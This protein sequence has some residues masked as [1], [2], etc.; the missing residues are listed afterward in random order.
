MEVK[1][2]DEALE[3]KKELSENEWAE[4]KSKIKEATDSLTHKDLKLVPNPFLN[5]PV[6]QLTVED[7]NMDHRVYIDVV[8]G[9]AVVLAIWNFEFTHGGDQHWEELKDRM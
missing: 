9:K 8:D 6:W 5:H 3:D 1:V 2:T 4:I 7:E